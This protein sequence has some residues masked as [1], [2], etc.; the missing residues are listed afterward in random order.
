MSQP[1]H[2]GQEHKVCKLVKSVYG[3]K[4]APRAWYEKLTKHL[5]KLIFKH[6]NLDD[7]TLLVKKVGRSILFLVVY[8]YDLLMTV[9][10]E[11]F[12]A[13]INKDLRKCF[14]VTNLGHLHYY[15]GI[16]VTQ[17]PKYIFISLKSMLENC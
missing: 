15:L 2:K 1:D 10:N 6:C 17:H 12:I 7:A 9:N 13:S 8:L 5:L 11:D 4:Q 3:L 16:E 14:E